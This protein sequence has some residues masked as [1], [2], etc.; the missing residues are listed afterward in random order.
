MLCRTRSRIR[1]Q[2]S[3][4]S[5]NDYSVRLQ[6]AVSAGSTRLYPSTQM[7]DEATETPLHGLL[8]VELERVLAKNNLHTLEAVNRVYPEGLLRMRGISIVRFRQIEAVLNPRELY[9][10][11]Y[12]A[13]QIPDVQ[14]TALKTSHLPLALVRLL[15]RNG[16]LNET[17]LRDAYPERLMRIRSFGIGSLRE[18]ERLF[19]P[20]QRYDPPS[21]KRPHPTLP[22]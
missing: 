16:I 13:P 22:D 20:G 2:L 7:P 18:V 15:A 1:T 21:G 12:A 17:Q 3:V 4:L 8:S 10:S 6:K 9:R 11:V 14:R 19:F 5:K